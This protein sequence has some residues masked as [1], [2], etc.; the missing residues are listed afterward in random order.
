[1]DS[2]I[3]KLTFVMLIITFALFLGMG[4][5]SLMA[6]TPTNGE[7]ETRL[8]F[9]N[10]MTVN[11]MQSNMIKELTGDIHNVSYMFDTEKDIKKYKVTKEAVDNISNMDLFLYSGNNFEPWINDLTNNLNKNN[12][13]IT[14]LSRGVRE[15]TLKEKDKSEVNPYYWTSINN[16]KVMLYNAKTLLQE[17]DPARRSFYEDNYN[18]MLQKVDKANAEFQKIK[19]LDKFTFVTRN[20]KFNYF[21]NSIGINYTRLK[22]NESIE[23]FAKSKKIDKDKIVLIKDSNEKKNK[24]DDCKVIDLDSYNSN[25]TY[26]D[27]ILDNLKQFSKLVSKK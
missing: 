1:M 21:L 25:I 11:K 23:D 4:S 18:K 3:K 7:S 5:K 24:N 26:S 8:K 13:S 10:I 19:G 15:E 16:Y 20:D 14:D 2:K 17:N 6:D 27:L 9:L 12:V 22:D